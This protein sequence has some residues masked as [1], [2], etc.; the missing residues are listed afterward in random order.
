MYCDERACMSVCPLSYL[1]DHMSKLDEIF[2]TLTVAVA[3]SP[4]I[5]LSTSGFVD[6]VMFAHD[7]SYG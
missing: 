6:D 4:T 1:E 5:T 2:Y 7:G 3:R